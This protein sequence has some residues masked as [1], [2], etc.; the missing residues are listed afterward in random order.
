MYFEKYFRKIFENF[1]KIEN[2]GEMLA[3]I[4]KMLENSQHFPDFCQHFRQNFRF[5]EKNQTFS[6]TFS[7]FPEYFPIFRKCSGKHFFYLEKYCLRKNLVCFSYV[8][9]DGFSAIK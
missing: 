6:I 4:R 5:L 9:E 8:P 3:K 1:S 2:L 7:K